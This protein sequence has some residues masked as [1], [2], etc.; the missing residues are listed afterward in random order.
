MTLPPAPQR[1]AMIALA[2]VMTTAV[3]CQ[4]VAGD[5][6]LEPLP[7]FR[8]VATPSP[9]VAASQPSQPAAPP[10]PSQ[11][12][13]FYLEV[14]AGGYNSFR[15]AYRNYVTTCLDEAD[16]E[17]CAAATERALADAEKLDA[18]LRARDRELDAL[19][20]GGFVGGPNFAQA[21]RDLRLALTAF[22]EAFRDR[23]AGVED[24]TEADVTAAD[25]A[26]AEA[27]DAMGA[28][29]V[30]YGEGI[31]GLPPLDGD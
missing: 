9:S 30:L 8:T 1:L 27:A 6:S 13:L 24:G 31:F 17:A 25:E 2:A 18:D 23:I 20:Q 10:M 4:P 28:A 7:T 14:L 12:G 11:G 21:D 16:V 19:L 15:F 22:M 26:I 3:G 5:P 29:V